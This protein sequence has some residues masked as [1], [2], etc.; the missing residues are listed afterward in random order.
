MNNIAV[1]KPREYYNMIISL[2]SSTE[3]PILSFAMLTKHVDVKCKD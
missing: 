1:Y 3:K 2:S